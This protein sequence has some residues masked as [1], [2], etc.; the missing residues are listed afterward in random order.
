MRTGRRACFGDTC[1]KTTYRCGRCSSHHVAGRRHFVT[2]AVCRTFGRLCVKG[3]RPSLLTRNRSRW[4]PSGPE[5]RFSGPSLGRAAQRA[6][7][8]ESPAHASLGSANVLRSASPFSTTGERRRAR[9][10]R[11]R[12]LAVDRLRRPPPAGDGDAGRPSLAAILDELRELT[13]LA[14]ARRPP[15]GLGRPEPPKAVRLSECFGLRRYL[16]NPLR[17]LPAGAKVAGRDS[18]PL[19]KGAFH[20]ARYF[21]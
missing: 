19:G 2:L 8:V 10:P 20:G 4:P 15:R 5:G 14:G 7:R 17:L 12:R 13:E 16:H 11:H 21:R 1:R 3:S 9:A 6:G 18:H